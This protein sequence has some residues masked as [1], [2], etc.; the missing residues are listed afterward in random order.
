MSAFILLV[1]TCHKHYRIDL[2]AQMLALDPACVKF[3]VMQTCFWK[4][5]N[6]TAGDAVQVFTSTFGGHQKLHGR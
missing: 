3:A 6:L 4:P 2:P 5:W 1:Q